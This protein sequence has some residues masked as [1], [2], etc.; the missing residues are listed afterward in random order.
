MHQGSSIL[1]GTLL[2]NNLLVPRL[3]SNRYDAIVDF[4]NYDLT[5][6]S[7]KAIELLWEGGYNTVYGRN[8]NRCFDFTKID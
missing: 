1:Q 4:M 8:Y 2:D 5:S 7:I 3:Q 6:K